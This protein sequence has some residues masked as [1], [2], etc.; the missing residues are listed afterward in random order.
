MLSLLDKYLYEHPKQHTHC[1][2]SDNEYVTLIQ[3]AICLHKDL[4]TFPTLWAILSTLLDTQDG[5]HKYVKCLQE[6]YNTYYEDKSRRYMLKLERQSVELQNCIYDSVTHNFDRILGL[7]DN[8][9]TPLQMQEGDQPVEAT[10]PEIAIDDDFIDIMTIYPPWSTDTNDLND[11]NQMTNYKSMKDIRDEICEDMPQKT[12]INKPYIDNIDAYNRDRQLL[13]ASLSDR[14]DLGQ[15]S[16]PG[17]Q[18]VRVAVKHTD[19]ISEFPEHLS[20]IHLGKE[21]ENISQSIADGNVSLIPQVDGIVDSRNSLDRTSD[22]IDLTESP[23]KNT[24]TQK[25]IEKTNEETSDNDT[26]EMITYETDELKKS[27]RK[28]INTAKKKGRTAKTYTMNIERKTLLKQRRE[29]TLQNA[30]GKGPAEE[31]F[32]TALKASH[33]SYKAF[34]NS[35]KRKKDDNGSINDEDTNIAMTV[36]NINNL[37]IVENNEVNVTANA[38]NADT[39][40]MDIDNINTAEAETVKNDDIAMSDNNDD[41]PIMSDKESPLESPA[42]DNIENDEVGENSTEEVSSPLIYGR[43]T[44]NP[45][46]VKSSK[47]HRPVKVTPLESPKGNPHVDRDATGKSNTYVFDPNDVRIHEFFFEGEP[48]PKDLEG[49]EEDK[50][51]EIHRAFQQKL[52]ER[53]A[54]R[55]REIL[56]KRYKNMNK[57]MI[58]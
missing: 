31:Y 48:N 46:K 39:E 9:L 18:Q 12:D 23:E 37:E 49:V 1:M 58:S 50:I 20:Q 8:G 24:K 30:K 41:N 55:E 3:Y 7:H 21:I 54:E 38:E 11:I 13:T 52:K 53:D 17:A 47:R 16:L 19:Q 42:D 45:T 27:N 4:T 10:T 32:L 44:V 26:D 22:S 35:H 15:N 2:S 33:K 51:L 40:S 56:Q 28:N 43:K 34:K 5:K 29:R 57:N 25:Q 36:Y 6:E 14:L